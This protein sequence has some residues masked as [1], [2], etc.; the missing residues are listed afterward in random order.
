M[1]DDNDAMGSIDPVTEFLHLPI[2]KGVKNPIAYWRSLMDSENDPV[3]TA[4]AQ[5][6]SF[7]VFSSIYLPVSSTTGKWSFSKSG[8]MVSK[9]HHNL[10]DKSICAATVYR[11]WNDHGL[12]PKDE[13]VES[14]K[15]KH[16]RWCVEEL[17]VE[18]VH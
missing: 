13:I 8:C 7:L 12:V 18:N 11:S 4:F 17:A 2:V 10:S 1:R 6:V 5:K 15:S 14:I 3:Q 9:F 16:S